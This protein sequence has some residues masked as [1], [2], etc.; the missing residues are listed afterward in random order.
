M[1]YKTKKI[2]LKGFTL[3]ELLVVIAIIG[4]LA[5]VILVAL[6]KARMKARDAQKKANLQ[7]LA[8]ALELYYSDNGFY[9]P[10]VQNTNTSYCTGANTG[11]GFSL[12]EMLTPKYI[13]KIPRDPLYPG[14]SF[15]YQHT[16]P[17][18][19]TFYCFSYW[20]NS[21]WSDPSKTWQ[22]QYYNLYA[23]LE[24]PSAD[25]LATLDCS[26]FPD[27]FFCSE[28]INYKLKSQ[29]NYWDYNQ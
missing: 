2:F 16:P 24:D 3:I 29:T 14:D 28:G 1:I 27:S 22:S 9:P 21:N 8:K 13:A 5:G 26:R 25:D 4:L 7:Q 17:T 19:Y 20:A 23:H 12:T 11:N 6:S 10:S 15:Q 18:N